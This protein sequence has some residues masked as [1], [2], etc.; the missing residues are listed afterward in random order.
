MLLFL[1]NF[2]K[3]INDFSSKLKWL[4]IKDD[5]HVINI[6]TRDV[7]KIH[8]RGYPQIKSATGS[9]WILKMDTRYPR[10]WIFLIPAC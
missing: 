7:K 5:L 10:V 8:T 2:L 1:L 3:R 6:M 9:K 4:I